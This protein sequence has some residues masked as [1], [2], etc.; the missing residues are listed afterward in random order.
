MVG[1]GTGLYIWRNM[2]SDCPLFTWRVDN[3]FLWVRGGMKRLVGG[4]CNFVLG[5]FFVW[6]KMGPLKDVARE[7]KASLLKDLKKLLEASMTIIGF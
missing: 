6:Y 2:Q 7:A 3:H 4:G 1:G 5:F